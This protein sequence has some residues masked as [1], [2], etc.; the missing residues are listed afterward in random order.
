M[1]SKQNIAALSRIEAARYL[2]VS[3]RTLDQLANLNEIPRVKIGAKTV[4]RISDLDQFLSS[5]IQDG[6]EK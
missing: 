4:F 5:K 1:K 6:G 3:T 2:S